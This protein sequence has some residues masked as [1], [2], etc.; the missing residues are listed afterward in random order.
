MKNSSVGKRLPVAFS[1]DSQQ[2]RTIE[3]EGSVWFLAADVC[4]ALEL[5]NTTAAIK[6]LDDDEVALIS[7]KGYT[8]GND[9]VNFINESGLYSLI[10]GSRKPDA[11]RFKKWVTSEV[12][13]EIRKTGSYTLPQFITPAQQNALQQ[14]AAS[15]AGES[16]S[17]R[18]YIWSRFNNHFQLGSYKQLPAEKFAEAVSYLSNMPVK[19]TKKLSAN[20]TERY[21]Y[22]RKLLEQSGFV[23]ADGKHPARLNISMLANTKVFISP[24]FHLLNELRTDG[25]DVSA[26]W[27]EAI[28]MRE[29]IITADKALEKIY[30][31]AL[32]V[33]FRSAS[34]AGNK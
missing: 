30:T 3:Q 23:S 29:A 25:Y 1:F 21:H 14:L 9:Q 22:P 27:D 15:K 26:P 18:A 4:S 6:R 16:G 20:N 2:I 34:V 33:N 24:L 28:A 19:E 11:R 10:L 5:G 32:Q 13:P 8:P 31:E 7:I 17:V 12:L